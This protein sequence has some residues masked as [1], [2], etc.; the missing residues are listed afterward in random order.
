MKKKILITK[1]SILSVA[2]IAFAIVATLNIQDIN[3]L[4]L[5]FNDTGAVGVGETIKALEVITLTWLLVYGAVLFSI[6]YGLNLLVVSNAK[7]RKANIIILPI[8]I[9]LSIM[10]ITIFFTTA[11][12]SRIHP[13]AFGVIIG[14]LAVLILLKVVLTW[15]AKR[16]E[17][18][19]GGGTAVS[20]KI[21]S[22]SSGAKDANN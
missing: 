3:Y 6:D 17:T 2:T 22:E 14:Y 9:V 8:E 4:R 12:N 18:E 11:S 5:T 16:S 7:M 1:L 21:A 19:I 15:R 13:V 10:L 20:S